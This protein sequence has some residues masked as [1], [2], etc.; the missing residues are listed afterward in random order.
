MKPEIPVRVLRLQTFSSLEYEI[1]LA[2]TYY[3]NTLEKLVANCVRCGKSQE[4]DE[5]LVEL[6]TKCGRL[7]SLHIFC[8][9]NQA[10]VETILAQHPDMLSRNSY[11]LKYKET[12]HPWIAGFDSWWCCDTFLLS[13]ATGMIMSSVCLSV[14]LSVMLCIVAKWYILQQA[15][16]QVN[17]KCPR[18]NVI[19]QFPTPTP[20]LHPQTLHL[21]HDRYWCY[22]ANEFETYLGLCYLFT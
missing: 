16:E 20:T 1:R 7:R 17:R 14:H 18:R 4:L 21:L 3:Q 9:L 6:S 22:L 15:S 10:T 12:P 5:V 2:C 11:T 13:L 19:L 8:Q